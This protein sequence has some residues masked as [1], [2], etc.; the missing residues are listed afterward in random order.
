MPFLLLVLPQP[1]TLTLH[2]LRHHCSIQLLPGLVLGVR[3]YTPQGV[4]LSP[5]GEGPGSMLPQQQN[6][7]TAENIGI[8]WGG[9]SRKCVW[10]GG[11]AK[12]RWYADAGPGGGDGESGALAQMP[13]S[14]SAR[15][16]WGLSYQPLAR[17]GPP[18][19]GAILLE[20]NPSLHGHW[21]PSRGAR[22]GGCICMS[23][24]QLRAWGIMRWQGGELQ[25]GT[26]TVA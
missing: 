19:G 7:F 24:G 26:W 11:T 10:T 9:V 5:S 13:S 3:P 18:V 2:G 22:Y 6:S 16:H 23:P 21:L 12:V 14:L 4:R 25:T 17:V 15:P 8:F 1:L 20:Q